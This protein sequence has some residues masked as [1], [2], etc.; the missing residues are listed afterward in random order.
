MS[1]RKQLRIV[2]DSSTI[3][4]VHFG[5]VSDDRLLIKNDAQKKIGS[6]QKV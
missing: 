3:I 6:G 1:N 5:R 4:P 2:I